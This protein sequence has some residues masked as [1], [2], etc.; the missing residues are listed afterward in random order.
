MGTSNSSDILKQKSQKFYTDLSN[1]NTV[2]NMNH[3]N[4]N[5]NDLSEKIKLKISI[6]KINK[7]YSYEIHLFNINNNQK[8]PLNDFFEC[9][10]SDNNNTVCLDNP[11]IIRYFFEKEQPLLI[12]ITKKNSEI[13]M[14]Y[15]LKTTLG[16]IMGSKNATWESKINDVDNETLK[17]QAEKLKLSEDIIIIRF[18][19]TPEKPVSFSKIRCKMYYE[20]YSDKILYRSECINDN[21]FFMPVKIPLELFQNNKLTLKLYKSNRKTR[22][23][24]EVGISEFVNGISFKKRINGIN[25]TITSK[26]KLTKNYTFVDYL[27]AGMKIGLSIAIDFTASNG[28]PNR[29]DSLHSIKSLEP[30][31]YERAINACG[32]ILSKY[33]D[34]QLFPCFGFGAKYYGKTY[35]AFNLN[36]TDNPNILYIGG[37]IQ[38]YHMALQKTQLYGP[39]YFGPVINKMKNIIKRDG[40]NKNYYILMILTDGIIDDIDDTIEELVEVSTL[41]LSV[42]IIGVGKADFSSME[43]LDADINPLVDSKGKRAARDLVQFVPFLK[44]ESNP[45][46]L[47]SEVLAEIPSQ[48][49][50]YYEEKN[51]DPTTLSTFKKS[52]DYY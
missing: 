48:I 37:I 35:H 28:D 17:I 41:P 42:I 6:N 20:I 38:A 27:K 47:A 15:E 52:D 22:I 45:E 33:N 5:Q 34:S 49:I 36:F 16:C 1:L 25:Y 4:H 10:S 24:T 2:E 39:T 29:Y 40:D 11:L 7:D 46:K 19:I 23:D 32:N 14:N 18:E 43:I 44:Y 50:E 12:Q 51:I 8:N 9:S 26:S 31:Q 3:K 30:N 21:G 13:S